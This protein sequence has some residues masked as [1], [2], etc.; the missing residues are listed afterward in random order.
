[1]AEGF[2]AEKLRQSLTDLAEGAVRFGQGLRFARAVAKNAAAN[3]RY[4]WR[5]QRPNHKGRYEQAMK[6]GKEWVHTDPDQAG[7]APRVQLARPGGGLVACTVTE[8]AAACEP[9]CCRVWEAT[10]AEPMEVVVAAAPGED[11]NAM[12]DGL[13]AGDQVLLRLYVVPPQPRAAA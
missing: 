2:D 5:T 11:R 9:G 4:V 1:M 8:V 6:E 10:P 13:G 7:K 12:V 3:V